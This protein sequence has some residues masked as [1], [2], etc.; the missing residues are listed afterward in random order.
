MV[1]LEPALPPTKNFFTKPFP[2]D[3][4]LVF[5]QSDSNI[6]KSFE[7]EKLLNKFW[8]K[9][10]KDQAIKYLVYWKRYGL[11]WHRWYNIRQ[12]DNTVGFIEDYKRSLLASSITYFINKNIDF[13]S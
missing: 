5:V 4:P 13:F 9:K 2:A 8:V 3:S 10:G 6:L 12:F 11:K 1:L 7:I